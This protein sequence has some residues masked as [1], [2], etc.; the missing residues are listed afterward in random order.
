M[1]YDEEERCSCPNCDLKLGDHCNGKQIPG[2]IFLGVNS[3]TSAGGV[4]IYISEN[5]NF[6]RRN[7]LDLAL[8]EGVENCWIEIQRTKQKNVVIGCIYRGAIAKSR[9]FSRSYRDKIKLIN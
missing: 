6:T 3:K 4:G 5:I 2:Y 1:V 7:D 8:T 9:D